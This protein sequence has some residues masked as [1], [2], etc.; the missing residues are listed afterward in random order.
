VGVVYGGQPDANVQEL[1]H[2][3]RASQLPHHAGKE[4]ASGPGLGGHL[5]QDAQ[6]LA[7]DL[8]VDSVVVFAAQPI[9]PD[10]SHIPHGGVDPLHQ[11]FFRLLPRER[12]VI[13]AHDQ[14][15]PGH[16]NSNTSAGCLDPGLPAEGL[17][18]GVC[19]PVRRRSGH[20][21]MIQ[22]VDTNRR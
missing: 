5:G 14:S 9:V 10:P 21:G 19:W 8:A 7:A 18:P 2:P 15:P 16:S 4:R 6:D 3:G 22:T 12:V 11:V 20:S 13:T 17:P 1:P